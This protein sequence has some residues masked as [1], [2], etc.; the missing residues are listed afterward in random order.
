M[1]GNYS[2]NNVCRGIIIALA[3]VKHGLLI[4]PMTAICHVEKLF[5]VNTVSNVDH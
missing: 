4:L 2:Q 5:I 1:K 3:D